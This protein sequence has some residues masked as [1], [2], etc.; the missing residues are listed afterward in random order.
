MAGAPRKT[1]EG[2]KTSAYTLQLPQTLYLKLKVY[3]AARGFTEG[4]HISMNE[5]ICSFIEAGLEDFDPA[6]AMKAMKG[7]KN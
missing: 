6:A 3:L 4:R 2:E 5:V 1:R 7:G